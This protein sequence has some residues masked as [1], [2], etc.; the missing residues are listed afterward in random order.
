MREE[1]RPYITLTETQARLLLQAIKQSPRAG[2][3]IVA[4][5]LRNLADWYDWKLEDRVGE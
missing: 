2:L 4:G 3:Q 1:E 5:K